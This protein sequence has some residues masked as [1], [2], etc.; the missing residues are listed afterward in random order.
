MCIDNGKVVSRIACFGSFMK[1]K[2]TAPYKRVQIDGIT[3]AVPITLSPL[4]SLR[5]DAIHKQKN[6]IQSRKRER[7]GKDRIPGFVVLTRF[8][9]NAIKGRA[10]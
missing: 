10:H 7:N 1:S 5:T 8:I 6:S 3:K 2:K 4:L 9:A